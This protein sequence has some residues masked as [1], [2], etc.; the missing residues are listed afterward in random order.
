MDAS[1]KRTRQIVYW[2]TTILF[3]VF[4]LFGAVSEVLQTESAQKLLASLHYPAYLNYILGIAKIIGAVVLI[5][6]RFKTIK[7]WAYAGFTIDI[8]GAA[9][10]G[11]FVE[12]ITAAIFTALF[13]ILP[14]TSYYFWKRSLV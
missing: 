2:A 4:M 7:E 10:S 1:S 8:L 14:L 11:Y 9:A 13:L 3:I 12:G 5:Q 6:W